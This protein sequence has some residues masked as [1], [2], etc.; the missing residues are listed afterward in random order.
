M[1]ELPMCTSEVA[2]AYL[3]LGFIVL[4]VV[5]ILISNRRP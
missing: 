1:T 2:I 4:L 5:L 3:L